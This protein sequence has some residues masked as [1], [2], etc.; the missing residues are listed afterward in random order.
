MIVVIVVCLVLLAV[1]I[2]LLVRG[3][4]DSFTGSA[5]L[6]AIAALSFSRSSALSLRLTV[7]SRPF[8]FGG[9]SL[10]DTLPAGF[11]DSGTLPEN[12]LESLSHCYR[13]FLQERVHVRLFAPEQILADPLDLFLDRFLRACPC[14]LE[15]GRPEFF[16][17]LQLSGRQQR[18]HCGQTE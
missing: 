13:D 4:D 9:E 12:V 3:R 8:M 5:F 1:V 15:R 14:A 10:S 11:T 16:S 6:R 17:D 7:I 2:A 18:R